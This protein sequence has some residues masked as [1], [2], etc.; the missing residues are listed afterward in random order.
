MYREM[1]HAGDML[2]GF[3]DI[4]LHGPY[5]D[6]FLPEQVR[7]A[8]VHLQRWSGVKRCHNKEFGFPDA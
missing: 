1:Q 3:V 2:A 5:S 4:I 6:R 7:M 8:A